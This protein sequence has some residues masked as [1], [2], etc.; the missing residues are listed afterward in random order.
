MIKVFL[1][2]YISENDSWENVTKEF[3][4]LPSVGEYLTLSSVSEWYEVKIVL[5][6][7]F[8][9]DYDAEVYAIKVDHL[10]VM[11]KAFKGM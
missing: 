4:A 11:K 9:R 6:T 10:E 7:Q 3:V 1:H 8:S 5:H 2:T